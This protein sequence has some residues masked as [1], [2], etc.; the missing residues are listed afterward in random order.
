MSDWIVD[1]IGIIC[2]VTLVV[3]LSAVILAS[4]QHDPKMEGGF[5]VNK[6]HQAAYT[7]P[8][9]VGKTMSTIYHA[10]QWNVLVKDANDNTKV[11]N[12]EAFYNAVE[13]N[14]WIDFRERG[15]EP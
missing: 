11:I 1:H 4:C 6:H 7:Q 9:V 12:D 14:A 15:I 2:I 8:I 5:V 13:L 3:F 10:E